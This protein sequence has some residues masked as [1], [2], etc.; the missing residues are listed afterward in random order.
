MLNLFWV[1]L[2]R[3]VVCPLIGHASTW[4]EIS[5]RPGHFRC[6]RCLLAAGWGA[7]KWDDMPEVVPEL[8]RG[9]RA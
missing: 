8:R 6:P 3:H 2:M 5:K 9:T 7:E 1:W 4:A